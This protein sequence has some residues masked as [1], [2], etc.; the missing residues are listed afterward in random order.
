MWWSRLGRLAV[1]SIC[2][3]GGRE[4]RREERREE[5]EEDPELEIISM[6]A[7]GGY[8]RVFRCRDPKTGTVVATKQ[9]RI[10]GVS[11]GVPSSIIR[12]VSFLKELHHDNIVRLLKVGFTNYRY[13]N[14][15]FEHLDCDLQEYMMN[16]RLSKDAV[17]IK[18]LR[19][20]ESAFAGVLLWNWLLICSE[21]H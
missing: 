7:E 16:N 21:M 5:E 10:L 19:R 3:R 20:W 13:V 15:T 9:I 8:G 11:Q 18:V 12:E 4:E 2:K 14:L 17:T 6:V 1:C